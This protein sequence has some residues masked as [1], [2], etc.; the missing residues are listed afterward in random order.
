MGTCDVLTKFIKYAKFALSSSSIHNPRKEIEMDSIKDVCAGWTDA[1]KAK[2]LRTIIGFREGQLLGPET[3]LAYCAT[4]IT[5]PMEYC[6]LSSDMTQ[7]LLF[8]RPPNDPFFR[9]QWHVSGAVMLPGETPGGVWKRLQSGSKY[10]LQ[11]D[12]FSPPI[13]IGEIDTPM[14]PQEEGM[15]PRGQ[16]KNTI[17][18]VICCAGNTLIEGQWFLL[19]SLRRTGPD[20][21]LGHHQRYIDKVLLPWL[22][23]AGVDIG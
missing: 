19:K 4:T 21:L 16:E 18:I 11:D 20:R 17:H 8:K 2:A 22:T 7:I 15:C 9:G 10:G 12:H 1:E 3:F 13:K 6:I 5:T 14:G 23:L